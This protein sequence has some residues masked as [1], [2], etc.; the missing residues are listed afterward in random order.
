MDRLKVTVEPLGAGI[1]EQQIAAAE[2]ELGQSIP[3]AYR[4]LL[5]CMNGC[6]L[7][8]AVFF[9]PRSR[10]EPRGR[11]ADVRYL[12]GIG[13]DAQYH[14]LLRH[15]R[16]V[17]DIL[18]DGVIEFGRDSG[19]N[20]YVAFTTGLRRGQVAFRDHEGPFEI[21]PLASSMEEF[22]E[23][24]VPGDAPQVLAEF[25]PTIGAAVKVV[26]PAKK[27]TAKKK[28]PTRS[29]SVTRSQTAPKSP[30]KGRAKKKAAPP[31]SRKT[32]PRGAT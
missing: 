17:K 11:L 24:L 30:S 5:L 14:D 20:G 29:P 25:P 2:R 31:K 19:G 15:N 26:R 21:T 28:T 16:S 32:G 10:E 7:T 12:L 4:A 13:H 18:P 1:S 23:R 3:P 22:L 27:R 8:N 6:A 9:V